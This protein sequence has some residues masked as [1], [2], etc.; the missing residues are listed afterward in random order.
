[1]VQLERELADP[2]GL[3]LRARRLVEQLALALQGALL[4][5]HAPDYVADSFCAARLGGEAGLAYGTLPS[6]VDVAAIIERNRPLSR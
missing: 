4:V 5:Q 3:E 1:M 2:A 6:G